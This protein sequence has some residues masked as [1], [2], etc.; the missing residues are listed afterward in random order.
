MNKVK[1]YFEEG[2]KFYDEQNYE[3][4]LDCF[5]KAI[6]LNPQ[7]AEAY[8]RIGNIYFA[9]QDYEKVIKY[10]KKAI[11]Y[12][13]DYIDAY[14]N[15]GLACHYKQDYN[16]VIKYF[17][18]VIELDPNE[19]EAYNYIG[20]AYIQK[21]EDDIAIE[22]FKKGI[23]QNPNDAYA[24]FSIGL[25]YNNKNDAK[26]IEY[27]QK[28]IKLNPKHIDSHFYLGIAYQKTQNFHKAIKCFQT[29]IGLNQNNAEAYFLLGVNYVLWK[30][31][32]DYA[33]SCYQ[34]VI[35]INPYHA[36]AYFNIGNAYA[37]K[38][39]DNDKAFIYFRKALE[40]K[41]D[42]ADVYLNMGMAY[43]RKQNHKKAFECYRKAIELNPNSDNPMYAPAYNNIGN[44]Y[45]VK[46][47]YN[48]A[49]WHFKKAIELQPDLESAYNNAAGVYFY[50]QDYDNAAKYIQ[51][52]VE[53]NPIHIYA[54]YYNNIGLAY[55][56]RQDYDKAI[57]C[58]Q[59]AIEL[60]PYTDVFGD[61]DG[62]I[63]VIN[64]EH[65]KKQDYR[66]E[67]RNI[68][69]N[70]YEELYDT[71]S[72]KQ[73][74]IESESGFAEGLFSNMGNIYRKKLDYDK[75]I[76]YL[77]KSIALNP[78]YSVA[79]FNMG[80][81]YT[82]KKDY[83]NAIEYYQIAIEKKYKESSKVY[84][85]MAIVYHYKQDYTKAIECYLKA[86]ELENDYAEAYYNMG[87]AYREKNDYYNEIRC[88]QKAVELNHP[89]QAKII[90]HIALSCLKNQ[91]YDKAIEHLQKILK[92]KF[93]LAF[94]YYEMGNA[95]N[96]KQDFQNAI[97]HYLK[98]VNYFLK[99]KQIPTIDE[100]DYVEKIYN[101]IG[102]LYEKNG[103]FKNACR[104]YRKLGKEDIL[105]ML[106][107]FD[108]DNRQKVIEQNILGDLIKKDNHFQSAVKNVKSIK[109]Y[110]YAYIQ[111][112]Y[113]ISLLCIDDNKEK[114]VAHYC[115]KTVAEK[116]LFKKKGK[117]E[118]SKFRLSTISN[119][120]SNDKTEGKVLIDYLFGKGT[121]I[122]NNANNSYQAFVACFSFNHDSLNQ[123]R[124]Y[125]KEKNE[126][127]TGV[128]IVFNDD[129]FKESAK[130]A[131]SLEEKNV[132]RDM[133]EW[134]SKTTP[135]LL[136]SL[137]YLK[138]PEKPYIQITG[139][140]K[141][142]DKHTLFRC[143]YIDP[144]TNKIEAAGCRE[145]FLFHREGK[146]VE[147]KEYNKKISTII[148]NV[149]DELDKLK[150]QIKGLDKNIVADLLI[151]LR[152]LTKHVSYNDERECRIV[153]IADVNDSTNVKTSENQKQ[154]YLD[155]LKIEHYIKEIYFGPKA[156]NMDLFQNKLL[157]EG[158]K[159]ECK[160]SE[161]PFV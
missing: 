109:K 65:C 146:L 94:V 140:L 12:K 5:Q 96:K 158:L 23:E 105:E 7:Y 149:S 89:D 48:K 3:K 9:L 67:Y 87:L 81:T 1:K 51:K 161:N 60:L 33:I 18:K 72:S 79:Y 129:F 141:K 108:K 144:I 25:V 148:E 53:L 76:Q 101:D 17:K 124:L 39:S 35:E 43:E 50:K 106:V 78:N 70:S 160:K 88:Y 153:K 133:T 142:T 151:N 118:A 85:E 64:H 110:K 97:A 66:F 49:L 80:I 145:D 121:I 26:T 114:E 132:Y 120:D 157:N 154:K 13:P 42:Y 128:S 115:K 54:V 34:K 28:A 93:N 111:S 156:T 71:N 44:M 19:T 152:Y 15:A 127:C 47:D 90:F 73:E 74:I 143:I 58:F 103:D 6:E 62:D 38:Y 119:T 57:E 10:N 40:L 104:Y 61:G 83:D 136:E 68:T 24:Y 138:T 135:E 56:S 22:Y 155:Y 113:I 95:Y 116:M 117:D 14:F 137:E 37:A 126:E 123:F 21:Y 92:L 36:G 107:H 27:L 32:Y 55:D 98:S 100:E 77:Q 29:V 139:H 122:D 69:V 45:I 130:L 91:D 63:L 99:S 30:N 16:N 86:I 59:R 41:P 52:A 159:I 131:T 134:V 11:K 102:Y 150:K 84:N 20:V 4:A 46:R 82:Q 8:K 2:N 112:I 125:G 75:S 31:D 147:S